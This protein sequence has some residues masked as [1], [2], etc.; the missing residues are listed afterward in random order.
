MLFL[1]L[2][3]VVSEGNGSTLQDSVEGFLSTK[4]GVYSML[5]VTMLM[6][7]V[8][9]RIRRGKWLSVTCEFYAP[10]EIVGTRV[11]ALRVTSTN[12]PS[13]YTLPVIDKVRDKVS[14]AILRDCLTREDFLVSRIL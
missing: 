4:R 13:C 11:T 9:G 7:V 8:R 3:T 6:C 14:S 5:S 1:P 10:V 2:A 12:T